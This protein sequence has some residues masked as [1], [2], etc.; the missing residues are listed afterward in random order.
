MAV[1]EM[2]KI[3]I[4]A[5]KKERKPIIEYIQRSGVVEIKERKVKKGFPRWIQVLLNQV[6]KEMQL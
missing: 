1:L 2:Q 4:C 5:L 3:C 6:L